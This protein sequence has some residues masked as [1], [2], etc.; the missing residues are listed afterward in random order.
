MRT[1]SLFTFAAVIIGMMACGPKTPQPGTPES[2]LANVPE[3][4]ADQPAD[5]N[6]LFSRNTSTS[7]FMQLAIDKARQLARTDLASQMEGEM[8]SLT[9]GFI[10]ELD[11]DGKSG[12]I[13]RLGDAGKL[14]VSTALSSA[15]VRKQDVSVDNGI[16]RA[17][18]LMELPL[19]AVSDALMQEIR[20]DDNLHA[21]LNST[22]SYAELEIMVENYRQ[23]KKDHGI[24]R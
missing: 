1:V 7:R 24:I 23:F 8:Q 21:E 16:Y 13:S 17:Y 20:K 14:A 18:V 19:G 2:T 3:W 6:Y 10:E 11:E 9:G 15:K 5:D 22:K 4:Y 12:L